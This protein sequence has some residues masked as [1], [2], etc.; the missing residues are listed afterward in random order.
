MSSS[1]VQQ[2]QTKENTR[3]MSPSFRFAVGVAQVTGGTILGIAMLASSVVAGGLVGLATSFR[4]LPDV[5]VLRGYVPTETTYIYDIKGKTLASLHGEAN[6]EVVKL[7]DINPNL[8]R[9]VIAMEDSHFYLHHGINPNSVGR[10]IVANWK[11]GG[12]VEGGS[13]L[14]MQLVKNLFLNRER[15]FSRKVAEAVLAIRLEQIF[16]KDQILE[17]YLNQIYWGHNNYGIQTASQSYFGKPASKLNLAESSMLAGLIQSPEEYSPFVNYKVAKERQNIVLTRM[18]DLGW[19]TEA[20]KKK[21]L[22]QKLKLGEIT[23]W[24]T[25]EL[26]YITEA[27]VAE[28]KERFGQDAI[29]KGGMRV[30]TTVDYKFQKMAEETIADAHRNLRRQGLYPDQVALAAVDPRTHFVKALVGGIGFKKSQFNR[31]IQSRRQPGSSFKPFVYY[32]AFATGKYSPESTV[33]DTPVSYR[34]GGGWYSPK[35]YGG[36]YSGAMSIRTALMQSA[37]VPAVKLGKA[38]G[39]DKV[40]E[41][42][43]TLGFKSPMEPVVSLPLGAIGVT[44]LEMAGGYATFASN[45]WYSDTTIIARVTDSMGNVLLDNTPQP[46]LVLD[47]WA[48]A[49]L[50][51]VLQSVV[52]G[53]TGKHAQ[54]GRQAAG[55]TGTTSSERDIWFVGYVPQLAA[56]VWVGND[57]YRPLGG[58]ATGGVYAAPIWRQFMLKA[59]QNEPVQY[60]EPA[61][62]FKRP[63]S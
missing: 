43:R 20:E 24:Q 2:K 10:A 7:Q 60:F 52:T 53:G 15:K 46:R 32:A 23:S 29:L 33:L 30:Q 9:S 63:S 38:V 45:G 14:T 61:S 42:C 47:Q 49:S 35:N 11:S 1:T 22:A 59:L 54:I 8:K 27:V 28:L 41:V 17:M 55:K 21:A 4:N 51:S 44:P 50:N 6:R 18:V 48:A 5:R 12:V 37:N 36:G 3:D 40:I 26:P 57:N 13:T 62:K 58:G 56:A 25:S 16:T 31:A 19:I 39:L 34:D